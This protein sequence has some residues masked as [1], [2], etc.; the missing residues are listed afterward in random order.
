MFSSFFFSLFLLFLPLTFCF[1]KNG[2]QNIFFLSFKV[3]LNH[4]FHDSRNTP[5]LLCKHAYTH[6]PIERKEEREREKGRRE[7]KREREEGRSEKECERNCHVF[8]FNESSNKHSFLS[9]IQTYC[10]SFFSFLSSPSFS[11][12]LPFYFSFALLFVYFFGQFEFMG[13]ESLTGQ[14]F[15]TYCMRLVTNRNTEA[16][17]ERLRDNEERTV[18]EKNTRRECMKMSPNGQTAS[19]S[20]VFFFH[21]SST[22]KHA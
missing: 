8:L 13:K 15:M 21:I 6:T 3:K 10:Y 19:D 14:Q 4:I 7:R 17:K 11:L 18:K 12:S 1:I 5:N 9:I 22:Y 20:Y 2:E 16:K